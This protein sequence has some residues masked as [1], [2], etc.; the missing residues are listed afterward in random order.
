[1]SDV[2]FIRVSYISYMCYK[3]NL[4]IVNIDCEINYVYYIIKWLVLVSRGQRKIFEHQWKLWVLVQVLQ[5]E[6]HNVAT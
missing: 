2:L 4:E 3:V 6:W 1:M 5:L